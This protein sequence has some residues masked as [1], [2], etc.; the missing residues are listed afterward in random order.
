MTKAE[1][2]KTAK[3]SRP[4]RKRSGGSRLRSWWGLLLGG[5]LVVV[6]YVAVFYHFFVSP[7]S[8]RWRAIYGEPD[9]P[10]GYD[11]MGIDVSHHQNRIDWDKLRNSQVAGHP[12]RFVIV[13]ATEGTTL[14]D[15]NFNDN[16]YRARE[17]DLVR[18]A[19]H[20]YI[21]DR[22]IERQAEFYLR[23]VHLEVGDLPPIL[24]IEKRGSKSLREFQRDVLAWLQIVQS[25]YGQAP[26]IYTSYKFRED[27]LNTPAFD[28]Y[29][30][31]IAH[32]YEKH[33]KYQGQWV[34]W[35]YTDCGKV[36]GIRGYVDFNIFNGDLKALHD[37]TLQ[38][39]DEEPEEEP[40]E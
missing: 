38:P 26:I 15:E 6:V 11:V 39:S 8:F 34:L 24:D 7:L 30:L 23:Q 25:V 33:L 21:P 28:A 19:Y 40:M 4:R 20:F 1:R 29:P 22:D 31:W 3:R 9:Y 14:I 13:K 2:R 27:Y 32:Y 12:L 10:T 35:Q 16:F 5:L 18:G 17:N 36:E 37:L